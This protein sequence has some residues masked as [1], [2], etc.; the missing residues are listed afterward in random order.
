MIGARF[1]RGGMTRTCT[2]EEFADTKEVIRF[3]KSKN[4]R[5]HYGQRKKNETEI[6]I[7]NNQN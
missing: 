2:Q 4:D 6:T 5:Q 3:W 7:I 1:S